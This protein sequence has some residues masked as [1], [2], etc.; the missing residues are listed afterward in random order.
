MTDSG[1]ELVEEKQGSR[2]TEITGPRGVTG[3]R[4]CEV[5]LSAH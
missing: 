3:G 5:A 2:S 4:A 1:E